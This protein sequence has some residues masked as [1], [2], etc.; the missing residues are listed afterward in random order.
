MTHSDAEIGVRPAIEW[1]EAHRGFEMADP[2]VGLCCPQPQ[3]STPLPTEGET[4]VE[5]NSTVHQC[6]CSGEV[7]AEVAKYTGN[8]AKDHRLITGNRQRSMSKIET[9]KAVRVWLTTPAGHVKDAVVECC[10]GEGGTV[11]RI[12][13]D[14]FTK[15]V[16]TLKIPFL[17]PLP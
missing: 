11:T 4:R 10:A 12:Q 7:F 13:F 16:E 5:F 2:D 9:L 8:L 14:C 17:A 3:P 15:Q 6:D 1:V